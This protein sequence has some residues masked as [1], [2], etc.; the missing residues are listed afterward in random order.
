MAASD[1]VR[2]SEEYDGADRPVDETNARKFAYWIDGC[3]GA[4]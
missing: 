1:V 2:A 4:G 3:V